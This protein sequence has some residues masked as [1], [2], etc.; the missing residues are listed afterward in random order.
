MSLGRE[1][2]HSEIQRSVAL[3]ILR[4]QGLVLHTLDEQD[5]QLDGIVSEL[6]RQEDVVQRE[7]SPLVSDEQIAVLIDQGLFD[8]VHRVDRSRVVIDSDVQRG[9]LALA[10]RI[11]ELVLDRLQF[12]DEEMKDL[13]IDIRALGRGQIVMQGLIP[14]GVASEDIAVRMMEKLANDRQEEKFTRANQ[15]RLSQFRSHGGRGEIHITRCITDEQVTGS[16]LAAMDGVQQWSAACDRMQ[17]IDVLRLR[18]EVVQRVRVSLVD[19]RRCAKEEEDTLLFAGW[20]RRLLPLR[21]GLDAQVRIALERLQTVANHPH[22]RAILS[23]EQLTS[24]RRTRVLTE[25]IE[26]LHRVMQRTSTVVVHHLTHLLQRL[27]D[28]QGEQQF[29]QFLFAAL[30]GE[31]MKQCPPVVT[32]IGSDFDVALIDQ[33]IDENEIAAL[34]GDHQRRLSSVVHLQWIALMA[35]KNLCHA[36]EVLAE[37]LPRWFFQITRTLSRAIRRQIVKGV[38]PVGV[39]TRAISLVLDHHVLQ[40]LHGGGRDLQIGSEHDQGQS[41]V[42]LEVDVHL[43]FTEEIVAQSVVPFGESRGE[44]RRLPGIEGVRVA[45]GLEQQTHAEVPAVGDGVVQ[46]GVHRG[47]EGIAVRSQSE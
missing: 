2:D 1:T 14:F 19:R 23:S 32:D 28:R 16:V 13:Q 18:Q 21:D 44:T 39:H 9:S 26:F 35:E 25:T 38:S 27:V 36:N 46:G 41:V 11:E 5:T 34:Q 7:I 6:L 30:H 37:Q 8:I 43:V 4:V 22:D 20:I 47:V 24:V 10:L 12:P 17:D 33:I 29:H 40:L 31:V 45:T 15:R 3:L 42:R